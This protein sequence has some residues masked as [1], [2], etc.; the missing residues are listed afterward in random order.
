MF[1]RAEIALARAQPL[2]MVPVDAVQRVK[3]VALVFVRLAPDQFEARRVTLGLTQ[4][5][6]VEILTGVT[7]GEAVATRGSFLLKTETLKGAIG[8][9]CC[10]E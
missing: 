3:D 4:G 7:A 9:G 2:V 6:H 5:T 1:A 8:A 10:D